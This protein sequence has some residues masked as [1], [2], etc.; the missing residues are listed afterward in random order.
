MQG[1]AAQQKQ[2]EDAD[3][4]ACHMLPWG[5]RVTCYPG[6]AEQSKAKESKA[7]QRLDGGRGA[8]CYPRAGRVMMVMMIFFS[9][10]SSGAV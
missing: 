10:D 3:E 4:C 8:T 7:T 2:G 6:K 5:T 1:K 9:G